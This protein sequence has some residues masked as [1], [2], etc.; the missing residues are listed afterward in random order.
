MERDKG[1][2]VKSLDRGLDILEHLRRMQG[3][4]FA[5]LLSDL[6]IPRSSLFH[7]LSNLEARGFVAREPA[8][9]GYRLGPQALGLATAGPKPSMQELALPIL[10]RLSLAVEETCGLYVR[11]GD[12]ME[13]IASAISTQ[14]LRYT[15][16]V[17][18]TSPLY[19][20]S[21]GKIELA[22][23]SAQELDAYLARTPLHAVTAMTITSR[24]HLKADLAGVRKAGFAYSHDE[25]TLGISAVATGVYRQGVLIGAINIAAP[26]VRFTDTGAHHT[27]TLQHLTAAARA[28]ENA[29][30]ER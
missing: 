6:R 7:L 14:A 16:N 5:A 21:A 12:A 26:S 8:G 24:S 1:S 30:A 15:M 3:A 19:A 11:A 2:T 13:V 25:F 10:E 20:V 18:S 9:N 29:L 4:S 22:N 23:M 27:A 28:F 17:G